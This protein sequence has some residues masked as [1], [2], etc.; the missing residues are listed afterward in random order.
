MAAAVRFGTRLVRTQCHTHR[1]LRLPRRLMASVAAPPGRPPPPPPPPPSAGLLPANTADFQTRA[2]WKGFFEKRVGRP[3]EWYGEWAHF[4]RNLGAAFPPPPPPPPSS[5]KAAA[6]SALPA[7]LLVLGAGNSGMSRAA[8]A[9]GYRSVLNVDFDGGVMR[10]M[11]A[12]HADCAPGMRWLECDVTD[13]T[14]S[15]PTRSI[16][17]VVDKGTLDAMCCDDNAATVSL[18]RRMVGEAARVL[19][20]GGSY[21]VVTLGQEHL[22]RTWTSALLATAEPSDGEAGG[23][24][25]AWASL[26]VQ[27]LAD[28][29]ASSTMC[30]LF[31]CATRAGSAAASGGLSQLDAGRRGQVPAAPPLP[32][33]GTTPLPAGQAG[34]SL[35]HSLPVSVVVPSSLGGGS[36]AGGGAAMTGGGKGGKAPPQIEGA[37]PSSLF[38]GSD[39]RTLRL[40]HSATSV[41]ATPHAAGGSTGGHGDGGSDSQLALMPAPS[42]ATHSDVAMIGFSDLVGG[43]ASIRWAYDVNRILGRIAPKQYLQ[44]DVWV[45]TPVPQLPPQASRGNGIKGI[46]GSSNSGGSTSRGTGGGAGEGAVIVLPAGSACPFLTSPSAAAPTTTAAGVAQQQVS[47]PPPAATPTA[48]ALS[49]LTPTSTPSPRF[50]IT[51]VDVSLAPSAAVL[52]VPM[53]REHEYSFGCRE[54][55][56]ALAKQAGGSGRLLFVTLNRGHDFSAGGAAVRAELSPLVMRLLP[57]A[58]Q[59]QQQRGRGGGAAAAS[60]TS[61]YGP[62]G[63]GG[64]AAPPAP[65]SPS[66]PFLAVGEDSEDLGARTQVAAGSSGLSGAFIVEDVPEEGEGS[67]GGVDGRRVAMSRRLVF[68]S[69]RNAVQSEARVMLL[70]PPR[71]SVQPPVASIASNAASSSSAAAGKQR[72]GGAGRLSGGTAENAPPNNRDAA[73][74]SAAVISAALLPTPPSATF[75]YSHLAFEFHRAIAACLPLAAGALARER[76]LLP[77]ETPAPAAAAT[78]SSSLSIKE[79]GA[80]AALGADSIPSTSPTPTLRVLVV[81]LGGGSLPMFMATQIGGGTTPAPAPVPAAISATHPSPCNCSPAGSA[82]DPH[83]VNSISGRGDGGRGGGVEVTAVEL[84]PDIVRVAIDHFGCRAASLITAQPPAPTAALHP[85]SPAASATAAPVSETPSTSTSSPSTS[86]PAMGLCPSEDVKRAVDGDMVMGDGG[87]GGGSRG[88]HIVVGDGLDYVVGLVTRHPAPL[89]PHVIVVDVDSK[90]ISTGLS[91]PPAAFLSPSFLRALY[92]ALAPGGLV[93]I[94]VACRSEGLWRGLL[95]RLRAEFAPAHSH[96]G[97]QHLGQEPAVTSSVNS[98][99]ATTAPTPTPHTAAASASPPAPPPASAPNSA[100]AADPAVPAAATAA[101][102]VFTIAVEG[103]GG[104]N[105]VVALLRD[106]HMLGE[107]LRLRQRQLHPHAAATAATGHENENHGGDGNDDRACGSGGGEA[108]WNAW[109]APS[110]ATT[111][112]NPSSISPASFLTASAASPP[113]PDAVDDTS[114]DDAASAAAAPAVHAVLQS[115]AVLLEDLLLLDQSSSALSGGGSEGAGDGVVV[116]VT[117]VASAV[118][119]VPVPGVTSASTAPAA[120]ADMSGGSSIGGAG[121]S[122]AFTAC[123]AE[124]WGLLTPLPMQ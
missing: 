53:G 42:T 41:A 95:G 89:L 30:P 76:R 26:T 96:L 64:A 66:I 115:A 10:E 72:R 91:F 35:P 1:V 88:V 104:L 120:V 4:R 40:T 27:P 97:P 117:A 7:T 70:M 101:A 55:Q 77:A 21:C 75:D 46:T 124:F 8:F 47:P 12:K 3:F 23:G 50:S 107:E 13:M 110:S 85:N 67:A 65:A 123:C 102:A 28:G 17:C 18:V 44:L 9:D 31:L 5:Q 83:I 58:L 29:D 100:V 106:P 81:G 105:R 34:G 93:L 63:R 74:A 84:D 14:A 78:E 22:L 16:R 112:T 2:Y 56:T 69:N 109:W 52:L 24:G 98:S 82:T 118:T 87:G 38:V 49:T 57:A 94:N 79:G 62:R 39:V 59:Q 114:V 90:D 48:V 121:S 108:G 80:A 54:G 111:S 119:T 92:A 43:V 71:P 15:V 86:A 32:V 45:Q 6:A 73:S 36:S 19:A 25:C 11:A 103:G 20:P 116:A 37:L 122:D 33:T 113:S 68:L 61:G 60:S 51:L 99:S